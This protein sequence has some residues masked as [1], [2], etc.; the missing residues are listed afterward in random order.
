[1]SIKNPTLHCP[2][3]ASQDVEYRHED[4]EVYSTVLTL[5]FHCEFCDAWYVVE[6]TVCGYEVEKK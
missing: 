3:C 4:V 6:Y 1:M 5:P 2:L